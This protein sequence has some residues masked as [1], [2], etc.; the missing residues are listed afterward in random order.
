MTHHNDKAKTNN[1]AE[2]NN[3]MRVDVEREII[4]EHESETLKGSHVGL[5]ETF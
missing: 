3:Q 1:N 2:R 4:V 5:Y